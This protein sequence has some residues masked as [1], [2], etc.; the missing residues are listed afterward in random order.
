[1][2]EVLRL[3]DRIL[4]LRHGRISAEF[5]AAE[6]TEKKILQAAFS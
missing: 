5:A 1:M 3:A 4:V 6:A 2:E